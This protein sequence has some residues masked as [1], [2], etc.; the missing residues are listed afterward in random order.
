MATSLPDGTL[1]VQKTINTE[2]IQLET[3]EEEV[4]EPVNDMPNNNLVIKGRAAP[5]FRNWLITFGSTNANKDIITTKGPVDLGYNNVY[6]K[7]NKRVIIP[8]LK[9][10]LENKKVWKWIDKSC[11]NYLSDINVEALI[12]RKKYPKKDKLLFDYSVKTRT[13]VDNE[14][15]EEV[16]GFG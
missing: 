14:I 5:A 15:S 9:E 13:L 7:L 4:G 8:Q 16:I 3:L 2:L 12:R 1:E 6:V 11:S 10:L